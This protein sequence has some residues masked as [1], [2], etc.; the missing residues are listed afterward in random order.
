MI[1]LSGKVALVTGS[2]RGIGR[3]C[4]LRLAQAGADVVLNFLTSRTEADEAARQIA[5]LGRRTA[6]IKADVSEQDDVAAMIDYTAETFGRIDILVSNAASGG[7]RPVLATTA[8]QFEATMNTNVRATLSLVQCALPLLKRATGRSKVIALSSH[9]SRMAIRDYGLIGSS[10]AALESLIRHLALEAG[11]DGINF[12]VVQAGLVLTDSI[13]AFPD[14]EQL[15]ERWRTRS[16]VGNQDLEAG[17]VAD[18]VLFL[19]SSLS[20]FVQGQTL[21]VDAGAAIH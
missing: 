8:A 11:R 14:H 12:N 9:G 10:K 19:A 17:S 2:S 7:F 20:D 16:L 21:V 4:A 5:D 1:S 18:A 13:R 15:F 6:V 3:K